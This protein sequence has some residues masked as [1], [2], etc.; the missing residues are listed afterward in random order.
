MATVHGHAGSDC[1]SAYCVA[2]VE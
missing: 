1:N 2:A